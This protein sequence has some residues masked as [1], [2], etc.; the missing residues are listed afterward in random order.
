MI[1]LVVI[2]FSQF[3]TNRSTTKIT[4][5]S[6]FENNRLKHCFLTSSSITRTY[7]SCLGPF[8]SF[9]FLWYTKEHSKRLP[10]HSTSVLH[11]LATTTLRLPMSVIWKLDNFKTLIQLLIRF[12][13]FYYKP[14]GRCCIKL[15]VLFPALYSSWFLKH[16]ILRDPS[17]SMFRPSR[18]SHETLQVTGTITIDWLEL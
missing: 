7:C 13:L 11:T 8:S 2:S 10:K 14:T 9:F 5:D 6:K 15:P 16:Q 12:F 17:Q 18:W 3:T 4:I 1:S